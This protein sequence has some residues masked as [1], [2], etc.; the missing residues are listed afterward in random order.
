[1]VDAA[2]FRGPAARTVVVVGGLASAVSIAA[3]AVIPSRDLPSL[4]PLVLLAWWCVY[5][6][7]GYPLVRVDA[8]AV[9]VRN[10]LSTVT[11]PIAAIR[12][13]TGGRRLTIRTFDGRTYVPVAAPGVGTSFLWGA[14]RAADAYASSP[15]IVKGVEP[16][17]LDPNRERTPAT[18]VAQTI[19][20]RMDQRRPMPGDPRVV[21]PP[22]INL[23][24]VHGTV[25][26]VVATAALLLILG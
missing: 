20:R 3:A 14:V 15:V 2:E 17:R 25:A 21:P 11:I 8:E 12:E 4:I 9:L 16:L 18:I 26:A 1:M 13:V 7:W 24:V 22:T 6:L 19:R 5:V 10:T 23:S